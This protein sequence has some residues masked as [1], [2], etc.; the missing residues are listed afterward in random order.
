MNNWHQYTSLT[1]LLLL[2]L[3]VAS[4][5]EDLL[6][7]RPF[8]GKYPEE[9][10][11]GNRQSADAFVFSTYNDVMGLYTGFVGE[12]SWTNNNVDDRGNA[13]SQGNITRDDN[14]GFGDFGRIRRCNLIIEKAQTSTTL[15]ENDKKEL[16]A[17]AKFLR[18]MVYFQQA[19]RFGRFVWIDNVLTPDDELALPLTAD[20]KSS[21]QL[22]LKDIDDAIAGLPKTSAS[23]RANQYTAL[24][25][26]SEVALQAAAYTGDAT[27]YQQTIDAADRVIA[28]G[29]YMID[30]DYEGMFNEKNKYSKEIILG[31]YRSSANTNCDNIEDLQN[32]VPNTNNN[33]VIRSGGYPLFTVDKTFEAWLYHAPSQNLVDAYLVLDPATGKAVRWNESS[34]YKQNFTKLGGPTYVDNARY[35]GP[36]GQNVSS[37]L[38][39]DRDKRFYATIVYDSCTWFNERVTTKLKGNLHRLVN[40]A[41]GPHIGVTNYYWRKGVYNVSP[42]VFYGIPTDYHWPIF[43]LSRVYLNKAEALLRQNKVADAVA[44]FNKS[45]TAHGGLPASTATSLTEAWQ[46]YKRERRIELVKEKDYYWSLLRWGKYGGDANHGLA[47]GGNIPELEEIPTFIEISIDRSSYYIDKVTFNANDIRVFDETKRYLFPIPQSQ[48]NRN[49]NLQQNPNW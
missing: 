10:V 4:C 31:V 33:N 13:L 18:A 22:V 26:Q 5:K 42:R 40:G 36:A 1:A 21:Y 32:V 25:L 45:R 8:E 15:S 14:Y 46:D 11:W 35:S 37:M 29:E 20:I 41:L 16:I 3:G 12:E 7:T 38:Y 49:P 9:T 34:H 23:G 43:R 6:D 28:N 19:K 17:E 30:P 44:A 24:A 27:Y 39:A 48:I 47:P 2:F